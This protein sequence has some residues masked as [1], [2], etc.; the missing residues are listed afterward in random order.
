MA[1]IDV[2]GEVYIEPDPEAMALEAAGWI[3]ARIRCVLA[4]RERCTIALSGGG[5]PK[6][7][8]TALAK[9]AREGRFDGSKLDLF[10]ADERCVAPDD[11]RSNAKLVADHWLQHDS[12]P[13]LTRP[14]GEEP[15]AILE[16]GEYAK[17]LPERFDLVVL[18]I[19]PD[20]HTA[21]LFPGSH[22]I[23]EGERTVVYV[24]DSPKPPPR[25]WSLS[26]RALED[27]R[28]LVTLVV[29][30]AKAEALARALEGKWNPLDTPAQ[31]ARRGTWFV[32]RAA[33]S[34]LEGDYRQ[35]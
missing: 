34:R 1:A 28:A 20:G 22:T 27:A 23:R 21:S 11:E 25:R 5:T 8:Y 26:P 19:G 32:D 3:E 24:E 33:A 30:A 14:R 7:V 18:G 9:A 13:T 29:G 12:R 35:R 15:K 2:L 16:A 31:L 10:L 17:K 6:P 4:E